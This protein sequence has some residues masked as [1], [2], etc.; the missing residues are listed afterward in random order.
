M[1]TPQSLEA[2][3]SCAFEEWCGSQDEALWRNVVGD[4]LDLQ[5]D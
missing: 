5:A 1:K 3:Y 4:G 2:D